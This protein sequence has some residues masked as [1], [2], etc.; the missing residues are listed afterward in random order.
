MSLTSRRARFLRAILPVGK[1][2]SI[3]FVFEEMKD[4]NEFKPSLA[5]NENL[6]HVN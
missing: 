1:V 4:R 6:L 3:G 2:T 5:E